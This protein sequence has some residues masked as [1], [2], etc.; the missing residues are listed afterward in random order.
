M[1]VYKCSR[2]LKEFARK[3]GYNSHINR[4]FPC[5]EVSSP[6]QVSSQEQVSSQGQASNPAQSV[7]I[8]EQIKKEMEK[9]IWEVL[10][11][12]VTHIEPGTDVFL[13]FTGLKEV[14]KGILVTGGNKKED[15]SNEDVTMIWDVFIRDNF[16][17]YEPSYVYNGPDSP[18]TRF[19][20]IRECM[21]K[22]YTQRLEDLLEREG[23]DLLTFFANPDRL[24][25]PRLLIR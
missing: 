13:S 8:L 4:K 3:Q 19:R 21:K 6:I 12:Y 14:S 2:C 5:K 20:K 22:D 16:A 23:A 17:E 25:N 18:R 15:G 9:V 11:D 10:L 24:P 7:K 1:V